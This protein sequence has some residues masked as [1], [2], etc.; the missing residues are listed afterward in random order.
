MVLWRGTR[1]AP[2]AS[3]ALNPMLVEKAALSL[4]RGASLREV[5]QGKSLL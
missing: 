5:L 1:Q 2:G 4:C 3:R